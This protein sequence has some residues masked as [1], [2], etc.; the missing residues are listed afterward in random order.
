MRSCARC[1]YAEVIG[2]LEL[3]LLYRCRL[4]GYTTGETE[5][6]DKWA[7]ATDKMRET[8]AAQRRAAKDIC[9]SKASR[10]VVI[11][12]DSA[13]VDLFTPEW[14]EKMPN[15][16]RLVSGGTWGPLRS[17]DPPITVPAWTSMFSSRNPGAL[18]FYGFRNR[19]VGQYEGKWIATSASVPVPRV[20]EILSEAGKRSCVIHVPQTFPIKP[21]NGA[22]VSCFLTPG[23]D[24]EYTYPAE[25]APELEQITG[26]YEIDCDNFR[27]ED[28]AELLEQIHRITDK[29]FAATCHLL[30]KEPWD[31]F[32]MVYMGPDRIQHGFW[33]YHDSQH[34]KYEPGNPFVNSIVEYYRKLDDQLG[35]LMQLAGPDAAFILV[36]DHGVKR[37]EGALNINDWLMQQGYLTLKEPVSGLTRFDEKLV[38]WQKTKAWAWGGYYSRIFLNVEGR[39]P[40][41]TI[42]AAQYEAERAALAAALKSIPDDTGRTMNTHVLR[43]EDIYSGPYVDQ[44]P[45]LLVY[46][47]DL[48]WRAGQDVGNPT[49]Y[50]FDTEIGPDDAVHDFHGIYASVAPGQD[51]KGERAGLQLMDVAPTILHLLGIPVPSDMEGKTVY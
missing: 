38:D 32:A 28:K 43:A 33:K 15:L 11:G 24:C 39:E 5:C 13:P 26:G 37:M 8:Q 23:T 3:N 2:C 41:G 7:A 35:Q 45:D 30:Q 50:S 44:A 34:R 49:I 31:L 46:F 14:L 27:T 25:L 20:W 9:M 10:V 6:C 51:E 40:Q 36:S 48:Y 21:F 12:W 29:Q 42:P 18:G 16:S 47:D 17:T 1:K 4:S 22:M 19:K